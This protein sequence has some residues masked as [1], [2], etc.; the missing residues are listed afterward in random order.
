[1]RSLLPTERVEELDGRLAVTDVDSSGN[2]FVKHWLD[3]PFSSPAEEPVASVGGEPVMTRGLQ[4]SQPTVPPLPFLGERNVERTPLSTERRERPDPDYTGFSRGACSG[5]PGFGADGSTSQ[6]GARDPAGHT[7]RTESPQHAIYQTRPQPTPRIAPEDN[8]P[9][10][11]SLLSMET[12]REWFCKGADMT[13]PAEYEAALRQME[14]YHPDIR[15]YTDNIREE[16]WTHFFLEGF[17]FPAG[18]VDVIQRGEA[19]AMLER[20]LIIR[21]Q[22]TSKAAAL[23]VRA[24][25]GGV[26]RALEVYRRVDDTTNV[27][28]WSPPTTEEVWHAHAEGVLMVALTNLNLPPEAW[29]SARLLRAVPNCRHVLMLAYHVLSPALSIEEAGLMT[30]LQAPPDAGPPVSRATTGF[31]NWKCAGRR[32]VEIGGRLPTANQ[33]HQ[34]F[35]KILS[36]HPAANKKVSFAFQQK[37]S[38]LPMMNPSPTEIVELL[39]KSRSFSMLQLRDTSLELQQHQQRQSPRESIKLKL[40]WNINQRKNLRHTRSRLE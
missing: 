19:L 10:G 40:L 39:L 6:H 3:A 31:Q 23:Y 9:K 37:S 5:S 28:L 4:H 12:L 22:Q 29:R 32:L 21:F 14:E 1:M 7:P 24:L 34:S 15:Q 38:T 11:C 26:K 18:T 33:L 8:V 16:R 36:K 13:S 30:Y 20:D 35:V 27:Y 2:R 17:K 25:L